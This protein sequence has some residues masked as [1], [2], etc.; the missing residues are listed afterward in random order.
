[1][2]ADYEEVASIKKAKIREFQYIHHGVVLLLGSHP[3]PSQTC[4]KEKMLHVPVTEIH[5]SKV[6]GKKVQNVRQLE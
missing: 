4:T 5:A 6:T 2:L 3:M 1:L